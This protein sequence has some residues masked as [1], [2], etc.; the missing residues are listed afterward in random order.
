MKFAHDA[1]RILAKTL[2]RVEQVGKLFVWV[3]YV[4]HQKV[5]QRPQFVQ[6]VLQR[7]ACDEEAV[8]G[9]QTP[10]DNRQ[11]WLVVLD[12]V[13][14]VYYYIFPVDFL[15]GTFNCNFFIKYI[16]MDSFMERQFYTVWQ[17]LQ[18]LNMTTIA[19]RNSVL[20]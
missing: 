5:E 16:W 20:R 19:E 4:R 1:A 3:K 11:F 2:F 8:F 7:R 10:Y 13:R 12:A 9:G 14:L 18:F 6:V 15:E 17:E